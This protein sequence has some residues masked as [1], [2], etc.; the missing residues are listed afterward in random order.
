MGNFI[1]EFNT[2]AEYSAATTL[3]PSVSLVKE[4][5]EVYYKNFVSIFPKATL[6]DVLMYDSVNDKLVCTTDGYWDISVYPSAQYEPL[7]INVYPAS[8]ATDGKARFLTIAWVSVGANKWGEN[9]TVL[10]DI[11]S[12]DQ[13]ALNGKDNTDKVVAVMPDTS[14]NT[15]AEYPAFYQVH[16]YSTSGTSEGDWYLPSKGE[17]LLLQ[18][19]FNKIRNQYT[20]IS[21]Q[22]SYGTSYAP[23]SIW[24]STEDTTNTAFY[25]AQSSKTL[26]GDNRNYANRVMPMI[27][28]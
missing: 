8:Q 4:N 23:E 19:N 9:S 7:A 18:D 16:H 6:C 28:L 10:G 13:T 27:A 12:A 15:Q 5:G 3:Y 22:M 21:E 17:L 26:V 14:G 11:T 20:K 1:K 25:L 2:Y 24:S